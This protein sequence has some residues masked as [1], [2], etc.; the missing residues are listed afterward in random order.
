MSFRYFALVFVMCF[1]LT[2]QVSIMPIADALKPYISVLRYG[3][4]EYESALRRLV[5]AASLPIATP[6]LPYSIVVQNVSSEPLR[7]INVVFRRL[8]ADGSQR[9]DS[10]LSWNLDPAVTLLPANGYRFF[11]TFFAFARAIGQPGS[12]AGLNQRHPLAAVATG[13]ARE[14]QIT[15]SVE[16]V[17]TSSGH[18]I[19][20]DNLGR[21]SQIA[22]E[23]QAEKWLAGR[24]GAALESPEALVAQLQPLSEMQVSNAGAPFQ[25]D[26][27]NLKIQHDAALLV[28]YI[29]TT[30]RT[31]MAAKYVS[32][33]SSS[34]PFSKQQ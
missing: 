33:V 16:F 12:L 24:L 28:R 20:P 17:I 25:M 6:M 29:Q 22:A 19:G 32:R 10:I 18:V 23:Q 8:H 7:G 14:R 5:P 9:P 21:S 15:V 30:G 1:D 34:V 31:D 4:P 3:T 11:S 27:Y 13:L 2:A 26:F